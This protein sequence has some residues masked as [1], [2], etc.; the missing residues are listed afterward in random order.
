MVI[1]LT[2]NMLWPTFWYR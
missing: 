2:T 1:S